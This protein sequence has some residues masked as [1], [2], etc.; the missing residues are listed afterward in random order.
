MSIP[1]YEIIYTEG[2]TSGVNFRVVDN[3]YE[4]I[5]ISN[6]SYKLTI[7]TFTDTGD[8]DDNAIY[9]QI[10]ESSLYVNAE[11]GE[12]DFPFV[13]EDTRGLAGVYKWDL[14]ET[15][16]DGKVLTLFEGDFRIISDVTK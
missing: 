15:D 14:Q 1:F 12:I 3:D 7:K 11:G 16:P 10:V 5:D 13:E 9:S 4:V 8:N 2:D 6:Y